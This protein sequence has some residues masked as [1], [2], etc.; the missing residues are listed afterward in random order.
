MVS[1]RRAELVAAAYAQIAA[2]GL[3]GLRLREVANAVGIDHSTIH[4]HFPTKH[5]LVSAVVDH[6]TRRFWTTT[7]TTGTPREKLHAHLA[8]LGRMIADEPELHVVLREIDLA[9]LRDPELAETVA[10]NERGWADSLIEICPP[11]ADPATTAQLVIATVKGASL[12]PEHAQAVLSQL[13]TLLDG[14]SSR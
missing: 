4:H 14:G 6:A 1:E 5:D 8:T 3:G 13:D 11:D 12:R 2:N 9:A 7:P 10:A